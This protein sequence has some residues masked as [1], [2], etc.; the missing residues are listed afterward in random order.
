MITTYYSATF[1]L[2]WYMLQSDYSRNAN[3]KITA[4]RKGFPS[5]KP[6]TITKSAKL[7]TLAEPQLR[8]NN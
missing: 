4:I 5:W 1:E 6:S 7:R 2:T 3:L 8:S